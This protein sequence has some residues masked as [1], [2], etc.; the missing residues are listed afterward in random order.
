[1]T[2]TPRGRDTTTTAAPGSLRAALAQR[3]NLRT[4]HDIAVAPAD[5][6]DA[7]QRRLDAARQLETA[8]LLKDDPEI[9]DRVAAAVREATEARDKLFHRLWFRGLDLTEFDALVDLHPPTDEQHREGRTWN[10]DTFEYALLAAC[11]EDE[12]GTPGDLTPDEWRD[13]LLGLDPTTGERD[14]Q[15]R[16]WPVA[17][18]RRVM[19]MALSAQRQTMA[20]AVPKG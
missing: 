19:L 1:M 6:I 20:D 13:E 9:H 2:G 15:R 12:D 5:E 3:T 8:T 7:A 11:V 18:Q 4:W 10:P 14:P 16:A 17:E